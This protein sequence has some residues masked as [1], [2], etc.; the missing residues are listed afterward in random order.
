MIF[1]DD[2]DACCVS[3][4]RINIIYTDTNTDTGYMSLTDTDACLKIHTDIDT[5]TDQTWRLLTDFGIGKCIGICSI[6]N[7][8]DYITTWRSN[9]WTP[10]SIIPLQP[11]VISKQPLHLHYSLIS[12]C[13]NL[14]P[15][16]LC[17][18]PPPPIIILWATRAWLTKIHTVQCTNII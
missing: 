18:C 9:V 10:P 17:F 11:D 4:N 16:I 13:V 15:P 2:T 12:C 6:P 5:N 8:I 1:I 14:F 3:V 7:K